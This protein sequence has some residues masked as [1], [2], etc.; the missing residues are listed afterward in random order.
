MQH[1]KQW[2]QEKVLIIKI[3]N[4]GD[5]KMVAPVIGA[6]A[7]GAGSSI[8]SSILN[9]RSQK[10]SDQKNYEMQKEFAQN[11]IQ[12]KTQDAKKA[13]IHPLSAIGA[14]SISASP[15]YVGGDPGAGV[16]GAGQ[17]AQGAMLQMATMESNKKLLDAQAGYYNAM[18]AATSAPPPTVNPIV[19]DEPPSQHTIY[20]GS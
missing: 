14:Q 4:L 10:S 8:L 16:R 5:V 19:V 6:A 3:V 18:A 7:I 2:H 20:P 12:W 15:S 17:A 11:S 1:L 13:G 9:R